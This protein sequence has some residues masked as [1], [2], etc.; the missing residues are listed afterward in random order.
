MRRCIYLEASF[1]DVCFSL[2]WGG[3]LS[4]LPSKVFPSSFF[5]VRNFVF[6]LFLKI[7]FIRRSL[8]FFSFVSVG[9]AQRAFQLNRRRSFYMLFTRVVEINKFSLRVL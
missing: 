2:F 9:R 3:E 8:N 4:S 5:P 7:R 6:E 1:K